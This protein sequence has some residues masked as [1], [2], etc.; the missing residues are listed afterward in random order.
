MMNVKHKAN[1]EH[2]LAVI[3]VMNQ[4]KYAFCHGP[5][6]Y[7]ITSHPLQVNV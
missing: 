6:K 1:I 3:E 2:S 5:Q 4:I 7:K